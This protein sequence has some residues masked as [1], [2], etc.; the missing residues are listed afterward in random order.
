MVSDDQENIVTMN[1]TNEFDY[2]F[3]PTEMRKN[4]YYYGIYHIGCEMVFQFI[5]PLLILVVAN[6]SILAQLIKYNSGPPDVSVGEGINQ[7]NTNTTFQPPNQQRGR[8]KQVDRA[9]VTL[10][11]CGMFIFCHLFKWVLN[12]YELYLRCKNYTLPEEKIE[13]I[14]YYTPWF[15]KVISISNTLVVLNSSINFYI[16]IL[17]DVCTR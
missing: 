11:I 1:S 7:G 17:K 6:I 2:S 14:I 3:E 8:R 5:A 12:I 10:A 13:E 15:N 4:V 9:K 16:Y